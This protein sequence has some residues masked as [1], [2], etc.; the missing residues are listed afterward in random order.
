F[1]GVPVTGFSAMTE[2]FIQSSGTDRGAD[3]LVQTL[4]S[5]LCDILERK[6]PLTFPLLSPGDAVLVLWRTRAQELAK[7]ISLVLQCSRQIQKN[8]GTRDTYVGQELRLKI[9]ISAGSMDLMIVGDRRWRYFVICGP[10]LDEVCEA[11]QLANA[12]E[13]VLSATSWELCEQHRLKT[14]R[15]AGKRAVKV[16]GWDGLKSHFED[17]DLVMKEG[18]SFSPVSSA[19]PC[20]PTPCSPILPVTTCIFSPQVT[21]VLLFSC[22]MILTRMSRRALVFQLNERVPLKLFPELRPVTSIFIRLQLGADVSARDLCVLLCNAS[23]TMLDIIS[24]H[25][26]EIHK[27]ILFDKGCTFLCVFGLPGEK[28]PYESLH[29][30]QSAIQIFDSCSRMLR[31]GGAVTIAITSGTVFCGVIGHPVRHE[32]TVIGQKVNLAARMMM[33]YPGL[34]S[35]DAVT[36]T[37]SRLPPCFFKELPEQNMK[38]ITKPGRVYQYLGITKES[39]LLFSTP[40]QLIFLFVFTGRDKEINL[41]CSCL[42]AYEELGQRHILAFEGTMGSGK[43][44]LL[45]ELA[46]LGQAAGH[47]VVAVELLEMNVMQ[48]FSAIRTLMARALDLQDCESC[49]AREHVLQTKLR[50]TIQESNYSLLNGLFLVE[51]PDSEKVCEIRET[52][53]KT[54]MYST[55][56]KVLE[57]VVGEFGIFVIDNAHFID[58]AS[59]S[60]ISSVSQNTSLFM[61]MS[62]APGYVSIESIFRPTADTTTPQNITCVRLDGLKPSLV[63]Q[64]ACQD[65][66]VVSIPRDLARFLIQR[67]SGI[68]YYCEELLH[69]LRRNNMLSFRSQRQDENIE[70][71]WENLVAQALSLSATSSSGAGNGGRVCVIREDVNL[72]NI[73]LPSTLKEIALAQLDRIA[74]LEQTTLKFAAVIGPVFTTQLLSHILS[75]DIRHNMNCLLNRLVYDDVLKWLKH[76]EVPDVLDATK[77]PATSPQAES[78]LAPA[79]ADTNALCL[80]SVERFSLSKTMEWPPDVLAFCVPLLREAAYELWPER[81]RV[82]LHRKCAA[83]LERHAHKCESCGQGDFVAFHRF[84]ITSTQGGESFQDS[85]DEGDLRSWEAL[86]LAGEHVMRD[87]T[88]A[89]EGMLRTGGKHS[90]ARSCECKAIV[91]LVLVPLVRHYTA[92]GDTAK[93]FYYLLECAAAYLR[94]SN[95]YMALMKLNEAEVLKKSAEK[96]AIARFE[97]ATFFSLKGEVCCQMGRRKLAEKMTREALRLLRRQVPDTSVGAFVKSKVEKLLGATYV[98]RR[99]SSL[100]QETR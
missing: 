93:A 86:V 55:W 70:D 64:K 9:G 87:G 31:K 25:N 83:F 84:T 77:V 91:E 6:S 75:A 88:H 67:S 30:L 90:S 11:E 95:N 33:H 40:Q 35:C 19:S 68:P 18:D 98:P 13:V 45:T 58:P 52:R 49:R 94:L 73:V 8:Y 89:P 16:G 65:L 21:W 20:F 71:N 56:A 14:E 39:S 100:P 99:A 12:S 32:Y 1:L 53:R 37:A 48:P 82:A 72:E 76:T 22:P 7:T 10:A 36:Y 61:V 28:V 15:V 24:P 59:W 79:R 42:K 5:Y 97:D 69:Y 62:L 54:K 43:N 38:G 41:F 27:V 50:G 51:F 96:K 66:G 81:E 46:Y 44:H 80:A 2:K 74:P 92:M 29:A 23:R 63:V 60:I 3:G 57:K 47:R 85:V 17:P 78:A 26:G 4:N 34:V